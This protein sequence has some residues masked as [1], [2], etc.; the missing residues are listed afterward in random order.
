MKPQ[1]EF[2]RKFALM[3]G[4]WGIWWW[5]MDAKMSS[6]VNMGIIM[7]GPLLTFP[8]IWL[9]RRMLDK[10]PTAPRAVRMTT[11]VHYSLGI[12]F[13]M[14]IIRALVTHAEWEAGRYPCPTR[15]A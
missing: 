5:T 9:A 11:L 6:A 13:G 14:P 1:T 3:V 15:S 4:L 12:L 2:W 8:F 7:G 10:D